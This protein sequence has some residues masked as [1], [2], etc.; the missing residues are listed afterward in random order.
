MCCWRFARADLQTGCAV[1]GLV[2]PLAPCACVC[3][4]AIIETRWPEKT[5]PPCPCGALALKSKF[6][7][8]ALELQQVLSAI[9]YA[10]EE[11]PGQGVCVAEIVGGLSLLCAGNKSSKLAVRGFFAV[12][13]GNPWV[14]VCCMC[15]VLIRVY[16]CFVV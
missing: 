5:T 3:F 11:Q 4:F 6:D 2:S 14:V 9:F 16:H 10:F 13:R 8:R 15:F 7:S 1:E 12:K